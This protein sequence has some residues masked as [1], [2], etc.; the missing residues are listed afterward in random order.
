[1]ATG[2]AVAACRSRSGP[3][4]SRKVIRLDNNVKTPGSTEP[5]S[6]SHYACDVLQAW[7]LKSSPVGECVFPG[8]VNPGR[9]ISTVKNGLASN[10]RRAGVAAFPIY[11]LRHVFCTRL[12]EVAAD[13]VVQR[14][15][16]HTGPETKPPYQL[17]MAEQV[18][19][20]VEKTNK[21][22]YGKR[23]PLH[24]RDSSPQNDEEEKIAAC[25]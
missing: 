18:R 22:L 15:M 11:N 14:A 6:L 7:K 8:P 19:Q 9:P 3:R 2:L 23:A 5:I 12:S 13:A 21:R 10:A 25:K 16:R 17:G 4:W 1:M 24:F 20:A